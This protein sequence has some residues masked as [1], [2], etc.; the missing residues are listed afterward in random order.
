MFKPV[1]VLSGGEKS[2]VALAR[3][4]LHPANFLILDEP[5]NHL[6]IQSIRVLTEAL[7]QYD[8][9]FVVV[10]HDRHFLDQVVNTVWLT[11]GGHVRVFAGSYS[12]YRWQVEHGTAALLAEHTNGPAHPNDDAPSEEPEAA[13]VRTGG[14]KT[15]EQKRREAEERNRLYRTLQNGGV[16]DYSLL[17][18]HQV[19]T[20]YE[21]TEAQIF[22]KEEQKAD[23]EAALGDP[24]L[25]EDAARARETTAAY[26]TLKEELAA[27]YTKWEALV[28]ELAA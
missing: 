21:Q 14:P 9:S 17:T 5:T 22:E 8:G 28:E 18:E 23:L 1:G 19:R 10:S 25:Y 11:E 15:K 4:L 27:L 20:L 2:R 7:R 3:T 26:D 16:D 12:D 24:S 6:D 13:P